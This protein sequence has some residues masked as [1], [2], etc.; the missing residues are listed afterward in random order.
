M[1]ALPIS[2]NV[3]A[4]LHDHPRDVPDAGHV[5]QKLIVGLEEALIGKVMHLDARERERKFILFVVAR[6]SRVGQELGGR[7][8]PPPPDFCGGGADSRGPAG[9]TARV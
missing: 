1:C 6:E 4:S 2:I 8:L 7:T 3:V 9:E 5:A